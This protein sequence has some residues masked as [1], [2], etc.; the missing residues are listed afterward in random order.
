MYEVGYALGCG[1]SVVLLTS[2]DMAT[3][4]FDIRQRRAFAYTKTE[5]GLKGLSE[6]VEKAL[7][8]LA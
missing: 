4:P 7:N 8:A 6:D 5:R 3:L 1:K 2:D